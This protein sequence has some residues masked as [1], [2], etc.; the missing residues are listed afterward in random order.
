MIKG[1]EYHSIIENIFGD[2]NGINVSS[3]LQ[4]N[5]PRCMEREGLSYP[6]GK[7]NLE[8]NTAKR[9]FRCWKCDEPKF[10]G[11]LKKL[12]RLYGSYGDYELYKSF[13][14][15]MDDYYYGNAN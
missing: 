7:Y 10:S 13:V 5:C 6:D 15:S 12:I 14:G 11:S 1:Q 8:I 2:V 4:V 9:V 3:Q